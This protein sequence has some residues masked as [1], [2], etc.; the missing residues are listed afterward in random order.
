MPEGGPPEDE[1]EL[2]AE[3]RIDMVR[4]LAVEAQ[5]RA[6]EFQRHALEAQERALEPLRGVRGA[7]LLAAAAVAFGSG[8]AQ[9]LPDEAGDQAQQSMFRDID[10]I[11]VRLE[12]GI[13]AERT[14]LDAL[15]DRLTSDAA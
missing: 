1:M 3:D 9:S 11:L 13:A 15:L 6:L 4:S 5:R 2:K 8:S 14:A 7:D 12:N 10:T